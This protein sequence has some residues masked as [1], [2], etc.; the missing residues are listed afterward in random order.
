M[1]LFARFWR[2]PA[3]ALLL[4]AGSACADYR[5]DVWTAGSGLPQNSVRAILQSSDGYLWVATQD[6]LARFDGVRFTVFNKGNTPG[7]PANR[8]MALHE[9]RESNLWIGL[10]DGNLVR[11]HGNVFTPLDMRDGLPNGS[12]QSIGGLDDGGIWI[13]ANNGLFY[14]K[15]GRFQP[16]PVA[17]AELSNR[18]RIVGCRPDLIWTTNQF[19]VQI[20]SGGTLTTLSR[21]NG[22]PTLRINHIDKDQHGNWWLATEDTGLLKVR[23]GKVV[24]SFAQ[25]DGLPSNCVRIRSGSISPAIAYEDREGNL[26]VNGVGPWLSR[27]KDGVFTAYSATDALTQQ[28]QLAPGLLASFINAL[29]EDREGNLWIG[30]EGNG[31]IRARKQVV[32]ALS[33]KQ[34]LHAA[35]I[36][37]MFED[38]SGAVW[39]GTWDRG[40]ARVKDGVVTNFALPLLHGDVTAVFQD[41]SGRL[42]VGTMGGVVIFRQDMISLAGVPAALTNLPVRAIFEDHNGVFWFGGESG[43]FSYQN[44]ELSSFTERDGVAKGYVT[45]IIEDR[46]GS[47][48]FGGRGGLTRLANGRFTTWTEQD[49]LPS[50]RVPALYEDGEG[51]LWLGTSDGGLARFKDGKFTRFTTREG[52]FDDGVFQILED[53]SGNFWM[54]SNRGIHRVS[55]R[56]LN[57]FA[58]GLRSSVTSVAYSRSD[59]MLNPECNG[60][61]WP[62]GV[63]T[64]D[65]RLWFPTQDG[66]AIINPERV[67]DNTSPPPVA[68]EAFLL[69]GQPLSLNSPVRVPPGKGNIEIRYTGLSFVNSERLRF[70]YRL[71]DDDEWIDAGMRRTAYFF[72]LAPRTYNLTVLAANCDG[73]W[74]ETGASLAFVVLPAWY[75]T[76]WFRLGGVVGIA[77][78]AGLVYRRRVARLE[79]ARAAEKEFSRR[80]MESQEQERERLAA[81]LHDSVGQ[82]LLV[83]K[84]RALMALEH[85]AEP[86][87]MSEQI[88]EVSSM[89]SQALREVRGMAQDL[90][91]FQLDEMGLT[92]A[93]VAMTRRLADS[94]RI[95]FHTDIADLSGELP[96]HSEIHFYRIVQ[97]LL[98]NIL[99]HSQ[100]TEANLTIRRAG[101]VL[102]ALIQDNGC[103]FDSG[104]ARSH[105]GFGLRGIRERVR[106]IGGSLQFE[107]GA[108][109]GTTVVIEVPTGESLTREDEKFD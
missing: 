14:R 27:L 28:T 18:D 97:E 81:E 53:P 20:F 105:E 85:S 73:V 84:N 89:A 59:G 40:L 95:Q 16:Y 62:T 52:M 86:G 26:W 29:F 82:N 46:H 88:R 2:E 32:E 70:K 7:I 13:A 69:D 38:R 4:V 66:V 77:G 92:R 37:P 68:I 9:D 80:L 49:G 19:G 51:V 8:V 61:C 48:W 56:E 17:S 1:K 31:L 74:N 15:S 42:W 57:E 102:R 35:N 47:L 44:G 25:S 75:Q 33:T 63:K 54:G 34:G 5:F 107:T 12:I 36:Y 41:R 11:F 50:N 109:E 103:G 45:A 79:R 104:E 108:G 30:T 60:G 39:L 78:M 64:H 43:L 83:I 101:P 55:K 65:G 106:T 22:L 6:G 21:T 76:W 91:P 93:I 99:K 94:S 58:D 24:K 71:A 10:D 87:R 23:E 72:R 100:A 3:C 98:T 96:K 67:L 90:R